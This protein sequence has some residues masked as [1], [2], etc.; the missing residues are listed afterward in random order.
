MELSVGD[1]LRTTNE[2][3]AVREL[4]GDLVALAVERGLRPK[5]APDPEARSGIVMIPAAD[6]PSQVR[7][8]AQQGIIADARPGH[9]RLSPFFYN[10]PDDYAKA[11]D[12]LAH[13]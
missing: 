13:P 6:P 7:R 4:T 9:V 8:L 1:V 10:V 3:P 5:V 2:T 11:I 12:I